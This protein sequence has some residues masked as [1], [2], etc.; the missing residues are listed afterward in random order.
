MAQAETRSTTTRR[1]L[2]QGSIATIPIASPLSVAAASSPDAELIELGQ[3][4]SAA[5]ADERN[6]PDDAFEAAWHRCHVIAGQIE[7]CTARTKDGLR[8]KV[9]A[10]LWCHCGELELKFTDA[11]TTDLRLARSLLLDLLYA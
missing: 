4:L 6:A 11:M 9:L 3:A 10:I 7:A 2:L 5:W 1:A 8:V